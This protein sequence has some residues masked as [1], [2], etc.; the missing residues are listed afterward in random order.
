MQSWM[1]EQIWNESRR[2]RLLK[3]IVIGA[4]FWTSR[5]VGAFEGEKWGAITFIA[6]LIVVAVK[7]RADWWVKRPSREQPP[8]SPIF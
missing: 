5:W 7:V 3:I 2:R 1:V 6:V 4:P 8:N